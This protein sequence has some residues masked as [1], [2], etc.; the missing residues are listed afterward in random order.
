[1]TRLAFPRAGAAYTFAGWCTRSS[2]ASWFFAGRARALLA[3]ERESEREKKSNVRHKCRSVGHST[4]TDCAAAAAV[5]ARGGSPLVDEHKART[6]AH[7]ERLFRMQPHTSLALTVRGCRRLY[8]RACRPVVVGDDDAAAAVAAPPGCQRSSLFV[9]LM[10]FAPPPPPLLATASAAAPQP[11]LARTHTTH[12]PKLTV[13]DSRP[14][15]SPTVKFTPAGPWAIALTHWRTSQIAP[16]LSS[17][18][19]GR[20]LLLRSAGEFRCR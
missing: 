13:A 19:C 14:W 20:C 17:T 15:P 4:Y 10:F 7:K 12:V 1:M 8:R 6:H 2:T 16:S 5:C 18:G 9:F 11:G 3:G